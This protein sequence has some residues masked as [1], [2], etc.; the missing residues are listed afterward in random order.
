MLRAHAQQLNHKFLKKEIPSI[1]DDYYFSQD[2]PCLGD[3]L[4]IAVY[5]NLLVTKW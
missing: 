3:R 1:S 2:A 4:K 5:E